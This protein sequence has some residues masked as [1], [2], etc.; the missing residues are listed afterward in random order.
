MFISTIVVTVVF[1]LYQIFSALQYFSSIHSDNYSTSIIIYKHLQMGTI[2]L[3]IS[4][5]VAEV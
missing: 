1:H 3:F 4:L 2:G 5:Q